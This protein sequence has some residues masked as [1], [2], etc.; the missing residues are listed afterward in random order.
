[1]NWA[2]WLILLI[3]VAVSILSLLFRPPKEEQR[4]GGRVRPNPPNGPG[5]QRPARRSVT[6]IDQFLEEINRRRREAAERR[7]GAEPPPL[8]PPREER[9]APVPLPR[10]RPAAQVE[11]PL[12]RPERE[13]PVPPRLRER[14][15][16]PPRVVFAEA[17]VAAVEEGRTPQA[18]II[19]VA[20]VV[21][22]PPTVPRRNVSPALAQLMPLLSRPRGLRNAI[23]LREIF[24][25]PV[26][27]RPHRSPFLTP[28]P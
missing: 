9:P 11:K 12:R 16:D 1:M 17:V 21:Q 19:E 4:R 10:P 2:V 26:S 24:E 27:R 14:V 23:L 7:R 5:P 3:P 20:T 28:P 8:I 25:G 15:P 18:E 13:K 22:A 6:D